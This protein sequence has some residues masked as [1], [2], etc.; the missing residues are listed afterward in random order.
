[1]TP[2]LRA[3]VNTRD[4]EALVNIVRKE[5]KA[6]MMKKPEKDTCDRDGGENDDAIGGAVAPLSSELLTSSSATK[7]STK[8]TS[9]LFHSSQDFCIQSREGTMSSS[10]EFFTQKRSTSSSSSIITPLGSR[11]ASRRSSSKLSQGAIDTLKELNRLKFASVGLYGRE[12]ELQQLHSAFEHLGNVDVKKKKSN[13]VLL[14]G[15]SGCGKSAIMKEFRIQRQKKDG[16]RNAL[17]VSGKFDQVS[18]TTPYKAFVSAFSQLCIDVQNHN[19]WDETIKRNLLQVF[20][21]GDDYKFLLDLIPN[22]GEMIYSARRSSSASSKSNEIPLNDDKECGT[23]EKVASP[24]HHQ[25]QKQNEKDDEDEYDLEEERQEEGYDIIKSEKKFKFL[26]QRFLESICKPQHKVI[27]FLDDAQWMDSASLDL[28]EMIVLDSTFQQSLMVICAYRSNEV[29]LEFETNNE[30]RFNHPFTLRIDHIIQQ[31]R[32]NNKWEPIYIKV[33]NMSLETVHA[34]LTDLLNAAS[35]EET[36][37]L[38]RIAYNKV[39]G[40][41][42]FLIQFLIALRDG[43]YLQYNIGLMKWLWDETIIRKSTV[44][45]DNVLSILMEKMKKLPTEYKRILQ[46]ASCLGSS[47]GE[48]VITIVEKGLEDY[49][50]LFQGNDDGDDTDDHPLGSNATI[51]DFLLAIVDEGLLETYPDHRS[52]NNNIFRF[53]HDQIE[54]AA[55]G[56]INPDSIPNLMLLIGKILYQHQSEFDIQGMLFAVVDMWNAGAELIN[57]DEYS[58]LIDLNFSAGVKALESSAFEACIL[59]IR[60]A[61]HLI[62][63]K[64]RWNEQYYGLSL[65][66]YNVL[67]KAEYSNGSWED[68]RSDLD[69]ILSQNGEQAILDQMTAYSTMISILSVQEHKHEEAIAIAVNVLRK[70]GAIFRPELGMAAVVGALIKTKRLLRRIPLKSLLDQ[71]QLEDPHKAH[72]LEIIAT[73]QS[74]LYA[75]NPVLLTCTVLKTLRWSLKYGITKHTSK[76]VGV[77]ALLEIAL[78]SIDSGTK[79][80]KLAL[81]LAE[82]QNLMASEYAPIAS[83]YGFVLPWTTSLHVCSEHVYSGY[84]TGL[85]RGDLEYG[86]MNIVLYCFFRYTSGKPFSD[87]EADMRVYAAQMDENNQELQLQFLKLTWQ[88]VL[89]L[90]GR[91]DN[92]FI[93]SGEAMDQETMLKVADDDKNPP[94]RSQLHCHRLQLAVYYRDFE[95]AGKLVRLASNIGTVNPANPII[96]RTALFDGITAFELVRIQGRSS[97]WRNTGLKSISKVQKW[98][99]VGNVNCVHILHLLQAEKSAIMDENIDE[100]RSLY[101]KAIVTSARN[102]F[103][104]DRALANERCGDMYQQ[105]GDQYWAE[106]FYRKAYEAYE[107]IQAFGKLDHM[108]KDCQFLRPPL[109]MEVVVGQEMDKS[110]VFGDPTSAKL[111]GYTIGTDDVTS[112]H[113]PTSIHIS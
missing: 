37:G 50:D 60:K 89:N 67:I 17:F 65:K 106:H 90:M 32:P 41:M 26:L 82:K 46:I 25:Q 14:S 85:A 84:N 98:I 112:I 47:F 43:G 4:L 48:N 70:L 51:K 100:A 58:L 53:N 6:K 54:L 80:S 110:S 12:E 92:T 72:A 107:Q 11:T 59:Y 1:M 38:A 27:L 64:E 73:M 29:D 23:D 71:K 81:Q 39:H 3:T 7:S 75:A 34:Y 28:L 62:P 40:N 93:L 97:R 91:C 74:S 95:L 105:L 16:H 22:L 86:F 87:L 79:A 68:L 19:L 99:D 42:F 21:N 9:Q 76:C 111:G 77:Y 49:P 108:V 78:G 55:Y 2:L 102:G 45:A 8:P 13:L 103:R 20:T 94:L 24:E 52:R 104:S 113:T 36:A 44:V 18:T 63:E 101:E 31:Q 56:L 61:I 69:I 109:D 5:D 33:G 83:A 88:T 57:K 15:E 35:R 66:M 10:I 96:W 30:Q